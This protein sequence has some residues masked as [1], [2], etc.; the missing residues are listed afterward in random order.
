WDRRT[1]LFYRHRSRAGRVEKQE[2]LAA[3]PHALLHR[4]H[5]DPMLAE[6]QAHEARMRAERMMEQGQHALLMTAAK[7]GRRGGAGHVRLLSIPW[8]GSSESNL[9]NVR[10]FPLPLG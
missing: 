8:V 10:R 6:R 5:S 7:L 3:L 4:P 9:C 2:L 1:A